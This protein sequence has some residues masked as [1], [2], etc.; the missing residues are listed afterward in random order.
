MPAEA[1]LTEVTREDVA[2]IA[3]WLKDT[4]VSD[5]WFGHYTYGEPA[6]LGY[7]PEKMLS[8][9]EEQWNDMFRDPRHEPHRDIFS[10]RTLSG[11]HIGEAQLSVDE[12]LGDAQ[13]SVLIGR[14]DLWHR[15]YGTAAT[16]ALLEHI[17]ATLGLYRA[18]VDVPEYNTAAREMF[19]HLGFRH[20][21]TLRHSRP[22]HGARHNSVV[23]GMLQNK[24]WRLYPE[25]V[26]SHVQPGADSSLV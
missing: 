19:R 21:G 24:Y 26:A 18:W 6:H 16:L 13:L 14:K 9:A 22:H 25:G 11:D 4:E 23:M 3:E 7:E 12:A 8:A 5:M 10:I 1:Q 2:R 20:E 17:F 15:G